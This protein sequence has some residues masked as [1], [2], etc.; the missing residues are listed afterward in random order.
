MIK[1]RNFS[2]FPPLK[3][4]FIRLSVSKHFS[5]IAVTDDGIVMEDNL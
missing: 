4:K 1:A 3:Y 2:G 5:P